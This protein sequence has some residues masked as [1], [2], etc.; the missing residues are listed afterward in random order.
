MSYEQKFN[1]GYVYILC[2]I[3]A[4]GGILFGYTTSVTA[5]AA[6]A[7]QTFF[8]LTPSQVGW[9]VS[10][11]IVGAVPGALLAGRIADRF[12]R[13]ASL[14]LA[15]VIFV[16]TSAISA[17]T[18]SFALLSAVRILCG[19]A[20][21]LAG[22]V[23]PM[24]I[25]EISP[26]KI[27]GKASGIYNLS[28]VLG[29][30][31]VFST[32]FLIAKGMTEAWMA[33]T[34][35]RWMLGAQLVPSL[36]MLVLVLFLPESPHWNVKHQR[37]EKA[38][39]LLT[40][41]YPEFNQE[42][43]RLLF[44]Q[45][46]SVDEKA[47]GASS[48][49]RSGTVTRSPVLRYILVVGIFIAVLQQFTGCN[50]MNY[51]GPQVLSSVAGS[52]DDAM[53]QTIFIA[54]FN[55]IGVTIGMN[56][57][58]RYGRLPI[59]KIGTVGSILGLLIASYG[60]YTHSTGYVTVFG[61]LFFMLMFAMSWGGGAWTL[62][63]EIFPEKI[64]SFGMSLAVASLWVAN[65]LITLFFPVINDN[66]Y[67]QQNFNGAFSMWIFVVFNII[68][69]WFLHRYVPETKGVALADIEQ[70]A[71]EKMNKVQGGKRALSAH[72]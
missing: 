48:S 72:K 20:I 40:R 71:T 66:A 58:D 3:A 37:G 65:F 47:R 60:M 26:T 27:R 18:S 41:I 13:K 59:M 43:A 54:L 15:A 29:Q 52:K 45:T 56:L 12:G 5:G 31:L 24:Y 22:T 7:I 30:I 14:L 36:L 17:T 33:E 67:L 42:E 25:S 16:A 51:Y 49:V 50:V 57:F 70:V 4:L 69:F 44:Q 61:V 62:I 38:I 28:M 10:S 35:W 8:E 11:F 55:G 6:G 39:R 19:F 46:P 23:S 2:C 64:R 53:F 21:G 32:N 68:C 9:V 63:S 34:G 1:S